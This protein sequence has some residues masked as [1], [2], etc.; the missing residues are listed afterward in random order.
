MESDAP[1]IH[2]IPADMEAA[3]FVHTLT[4][5]DRERDAIGV[6]VVVHVSDAGNVAYA[7]INDP[8]SLGHGSQRWLRHA[9]RGASPGGW[10]ELHDSRIDDRI[11]EWKTRNA[12]QLD[13]RLIDFSKRAW[14]LDA[15]APY[16]VEFP[17]FAWEDAAS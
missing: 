11:G 4:R 6:H 17:V 15:T 1:I 16:A 13:R 10:S 7:R 5:P 3:T 8:E 12:D 9:R 2:A 14:A